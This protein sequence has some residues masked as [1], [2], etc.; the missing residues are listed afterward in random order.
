MLI[1]TLAYLSKANYLSPAPQEY[2]VL[3]TEAAP[4]YTYQGI[5]FCRDFP[6][7]LK[8]LKTH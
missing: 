4:D 5:V 8:G 6:E 1:P 2:R 3:H 7:N